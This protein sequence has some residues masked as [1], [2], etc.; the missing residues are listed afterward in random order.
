MLPSF[1]DDI[2]LEF[3]A[4]SEKSALSTFGN[5]SAVRDKI[6]IPKAELWSLYKHLLLWLNE[7]GVFYENYAV[8]LDCG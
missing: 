6:L 2:E 1:G 3:R 4:S 8:V 5:F 7:K